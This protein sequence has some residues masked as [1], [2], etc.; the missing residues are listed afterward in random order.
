MA[1]EKKTIQV[2]LLKEFANNYL[3]IPMVSIQEKMGIITMIEKVLHQS[4]A[5]KGYMYLKLEENNTPPA[6]ETEGWVTRKYF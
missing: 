4:N 2:E 1:K 3:A 5:Y 6:F